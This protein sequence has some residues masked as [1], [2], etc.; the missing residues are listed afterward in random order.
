MVILNGTGA[1]AQWLAL[2]MLS[3]AAGALFAWIHVPAALLLGPMLAGIAF[4]AA[5]ATV[6]VSP[7]AFALAQGVI[8][9]MIAKMA[10]LAIGA[11]ILD[12]WPIFVFGVL[13]VIAASVCLGWVMTRMRVLPGTTILWGSS[14]GAA[15]AMIV[16]AEAYGADARLVAFMQYLRVA[17]VTAF[18]SIVAR[19]YGLDLSHGAPTGTLFPDIHWLSFAET[20]ALATSGPLIGEKLRIRSGAFLLPLV[21]G[22]I[23]IHLGWLVVELPPWLLV[24][25]YAV[26]GWSIGLRFTRELLAHV[27]K[28]F[29]RV[30]ACMI[31][32]ILVCAALAGLLV[33]IAGIDPLTAYLATSPGGADSVAIIAASSN[34]DVPFVLAMQTLRLVAVLFLAPVM[35]KLIPSQ[36]AA[37]PS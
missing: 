35:A 31:V 30:L 9:C 15:T 24:L 3:A 16:M 1:T 37:N 17:L 25:S 18:A 10:P 2:I 29:P 14:P 23:L 4:A 13:A 7:A 36:P 26:V 8:G 32:L 20:L 33:V 11:E 27:A 5:G 28:A 21:A 34:V 12:R 6:R 22:V 19:V